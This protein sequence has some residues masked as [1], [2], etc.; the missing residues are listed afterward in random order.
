MIY[1]EFK[2]LK[3]S[4]LGMG[5][6]RLPYTG[7][8]SKNIDKDATRE[9]IAYALE[10]GINY[11]DTAW[12]YHGGMSEAVMGE[13]LSEYPRDSFYFATKFSRWDEGIKGKIDEIFEAQ[14]KRCKTDYFDFYMFHCV[15]ENNI[16][17]YTDNDL[18]LFDYLIKQKENGRIKHLGFSTHG[19]L[20]TMKRF[21]DTYGKDIEFCQIQ[22]N[23]L[24]WSFQK[25]KEKVEL[26]SSYGVPVW[27]M[28]PVRGGRIASLEP[29]QESRLKSL[30]PNASIP[31]WAFRFIQTI[32]E[33]VVTL[34]G[35]S[36]LD[37][38]KENI[39]TYESLQPLNERE[40]QTL[41]EISSEIIAK[42]AVPCTSCR[43]CVDTC[44][45]K[46]DIPELLKR[47]NEHAYS[48]AASIPATSLDGID[49]DKTPSACLGCASCEELCPQGIKISDIMAKFRDRLSN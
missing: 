19:S 2:G 28:E 35:M 45:M 48:D 21:L 44:P 4:A 23:W 14:L 24:D 47:Y 18:G 42:T 25:A 38:I 49:C 8:D 20:H 46:L 6:M 12:V 1:N 33:V 41:S 7:G 36:T 29:D 34:S 37:Q 31:E 10:N 13:I 11:F 16:D 30:R 43:Y 26:V 15:N 22:I 9:M 3:I 27:V 39:A 5:C 32:P 40:M 17:P